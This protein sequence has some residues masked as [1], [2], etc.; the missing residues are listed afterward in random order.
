MQLAQNTIELNNLHAKSLSVKMNK[1]LAEL[2]H[3]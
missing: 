3:V 1:N 2:I